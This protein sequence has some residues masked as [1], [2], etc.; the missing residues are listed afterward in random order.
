[1]GIGFA[2]EIVED[3]SVVVGEELGGKKEGKRK[4]KRK[5]YLQGFPRFPFTSL[6]GVVPL[7][8]L[9]SGSAPFSIKIV[10]ASTAPFLAA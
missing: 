2:A 1:M 6:R 7:S 4:E 8:F 9:I 10:A 3:F 5:T